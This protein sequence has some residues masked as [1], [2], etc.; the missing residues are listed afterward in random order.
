M[1]HEVACNMFVRAKYFSVQHVV[2][3]CMCFVFVFACNMFDPNIRTIISSA[4]RHQKFGNFNFLNRVS[5][6]EIYSI[7]QIRVGFSERF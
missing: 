7:D 2:V 3:V 1:E 5:M 6:L 4:S